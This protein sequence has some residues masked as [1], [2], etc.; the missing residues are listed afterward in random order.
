M[1]ISVHAQKETCLPHPSC[2]ESLGTNRHPTG[3][4]GAPMDRTS[5]FRWVLV[6]SWLNRGMGSHHM[7]GQPLLQ[8]KEQNSRQNYAKFN[9]WRTTYPQVASY[10]FVNQIW[11]LEWNP[12]S[13][14]QREPKTISAFLNSFL[15]GVPISR[16]KTLN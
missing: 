7:P 10:P 8:E 15:N 5:E 11:C 16:T 9:S 3:S 6:S 14:I 1:P 13:Y 2:G 12:R 4:S